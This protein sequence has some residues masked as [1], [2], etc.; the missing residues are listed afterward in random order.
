VGHL[1]VALLHLLALLTLLLFLALLPHLLLLPLLPTHFLANHF[2]P[3]LTPLHEFFVHTVPS[4]AGCP[5]GV[6]MGF[7]SNLVLAHHILTV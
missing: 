3:L 2:S 4:L 7:D 6:P 5:L 1:E